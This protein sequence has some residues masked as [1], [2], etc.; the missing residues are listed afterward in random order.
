MPVTASPYFGSLSEMECPPAIAPPAC[1][2]LPCHCALATSRTAVTRG[3]PA[4][5]VP[6]REATRLGDASVDRVMSSSIYILFDLYKS[7]AVVMII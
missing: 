7:I 2:T 5:P 6:L 4:R 1:S 3:E